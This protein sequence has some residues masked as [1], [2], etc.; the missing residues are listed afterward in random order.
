MCL[1]CRPTHSYQAHKCIICV[2]CLTCVGPAHSYHTQNVFHEL[3]I[4]FTCCCIY[5][6][7]LWTHM[8]GWTL[9]RL[10]HMNEWFH[11]R[12]KRIVPFISIRCEHSFSCDTHSHVTLIHMWHS[13]R[14][15]RTQSYRHRVRLCT[16]TDSSFRI[17]N[18]THMNEFLCHTYERVCM[19]H[20]WTSFYT[21]YAYVTWQIRH[22]PLFISNSKMRN[23]THMNESRHIC[24]SRIWMSHV[25]YA[26]WLIYLCCDCFV[27]VGTYSCVWHDSFFHTATHCNIL[28]H[29]ATHCITL[30]FDSCVRHD[31]CVCHD[32]CCDM[33]HSSM[34]HDSFLYVTWL[35]PLC[36]MTHIEERVMSHRGRS[37]V[38]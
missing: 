30:I 20:I 31:S 1:T 2:M 13:F 5:V 18:A 16:M 8:C 27:F 14:C 25:T 3:V 36:D 19:S 17:R 33:T 11:L 35:L 34:W 15:E 32:S 12:Y 38:T 21:M 28:Q 9:V 29:T 7:T 37:H 10:S 26:T 6:D 22:V 24:M 23:V 4:C